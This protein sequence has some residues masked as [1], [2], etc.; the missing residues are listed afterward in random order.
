MVAGVLEDGSGGVAGVSAFECNLNAGFEEVLLELD[1]MVV[2]GSAQDFC[3][4]VAHLRE[5]AG[6]FDN[7][8]HCDDAGVWGERA[9]WLMVGASIGASMM[10]HV[11]NR[12]SIPTS[13]MY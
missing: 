11:G 5:E 8:I 4:V 6:D 10:M 2:V 12:I 13:L 9:R 3:S 7:G 1:N